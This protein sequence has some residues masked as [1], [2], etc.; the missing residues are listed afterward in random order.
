MHGRE[1]GLLKSKVQVGLECIITRFSLGDLML[2]S[3]S[4]GAAAPKR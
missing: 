2:R 3:Q 1:G 4:G